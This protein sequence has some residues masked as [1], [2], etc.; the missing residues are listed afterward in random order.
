[1]YTTTLH[2]KNI[3]L[4]VSY[5]SENVIFFV[6]KKKA[7]LLWFFKQ[8]KLTDKWNYIGIP[9]VAC[10]KAML[11]NE[12]SNSFVHSVYY[13]AREAGSCWMDM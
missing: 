7:L 12:K 13:R 6:K 3:Y 11:C 5:N 4:Y 9:E 8:E 1:M 10:N 2:Q